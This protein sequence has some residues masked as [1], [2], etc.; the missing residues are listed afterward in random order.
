MPMMTFLSILNFSKPNLQHTTGV[1]TV[2]PVIANPQTSCAEVQQH[3]WTRHLTTECTTA[4][5]SSSDPGNKLRKAA[6]FSYFYSLGTFQLA[7]FDFLS[8]QE[9]ASLLLW[10]CTY[11][12]GTD[13]TYF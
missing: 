12:N 4:L 8:C 2:T 5:F 10:S 3:G 11:Y 9:T 6:L 13:E 1:N 7:Y